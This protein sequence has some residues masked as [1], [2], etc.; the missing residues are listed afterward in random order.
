VYWHILLGAD[1]RARAAASSAQQKLRQ[2]KGFHMTP[3]DWLHI[4]TLVSGV[5]S[6]MAADDIR[7]MLAR[8]RSLMSA[9]SPIN[10]SFE[11]VFYHPEAIVLRVKQDWALRPVFEIATDATRVVMGKESIASADFQSWAPHMTLCYSTQKQIAEPVI[12]A[13][14]R[15]VPRFDIT[16]N[17]LSLVVQRGPER[18][19]DWHRLGEVPLCSRDQRTANI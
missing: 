16:I 5:S 6:E 1:E 13:L 18:L 11:G 9:V 4:T 12:T 2:F 17:S 8:A 14:G 10:V 15:K 3:L 19:W 7:K